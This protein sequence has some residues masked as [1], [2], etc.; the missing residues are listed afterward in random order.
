MVKLNRVLYNRLNKIDRYIADVYKGA[1]V[2][3]N[4]KKN[5]DRISQSA[6]S[7]RE[8]LRLIV[9][10]YNEEKGIEKEPRQENKNSEK[11]NF[12]DILEMSMDPISSNED[13]TD[14]LH[15]LNKS[16]KYFVAM[17]HHGKAP[18]INDFLEKLH[19]Y[20]NDLL[21]FTQDYDSSLKKVKTFLNECKHSLEDF[22]LLKSELKT[23][24]L[25]MHFFQNAPIAWLKKLFEA[26]YFNNPSK[27]I[28]KTGNMPHW[29]QSKYLIRA[30]ESHDQDINKLIISIISQCTISPSIQDRNVTII[31][32]FVKIAEIMPIDESREIINI[33]LKKIG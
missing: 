14:L 22:S 3:L 33:L 9:D 7:I 29:W 5:P 1:I 2:V 6:N 31:E 28:S 27:K 18:S 20:E 26:G 12:V 19:L 4:N 16:N 25:R 15:E 24:S 21:K 13:F 11:G 23:H 8:L 10:K 17:T 32:D 30:A